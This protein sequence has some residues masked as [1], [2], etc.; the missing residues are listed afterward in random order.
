M[1]IQQRIDPATD[2]HPIDPTGAIPAARGGD[3][4]GLIDKVRSAVFWRSGSQI[5]AQMVMWASTFLVIRL[6]DPGDYG[7]FAMTQVILVFLNLLNGYGLASALVR[8]RECTR[9]QQQQVLGML[10]LLNFSLGFAQFLCAPFVA[11]YFGEPMVADLL[12]VQALLYVATPFM[13]LPHALLSRS[14]DFKRPAQVH[15]ISATLSAT[16]AYLCASNGWGVWTLIAA[17]MVFF[18]AEGIGMTWAARSWMW[19]RFDF[20]GSGHLFRFGGAMMLVQFFWFVQSQSDVFIAGR[21]LSAHDLG[22]YTTALFLTQILAGK[23]VPPLNEV[24]FAAYAKIQDDRAMVATGFA[25]TVRLILLITLPAYFGMAVTADP[26]IRTFLGEKW[27]ETIPVIPILALAMPFLTLQILFAP[28]TNAI[29]RPGIA[30]SNAI[31]GGIILPLAFLIGV[32]GGVIGLATGWLA[33]MILL[34]LVSAARALPVIGTPGLALARAIAP[35]LLASAAMAAL[36]LAVDAMLPILPPAARLGVLAAT[37]AVAYAAL[38][39]FF[40]RSLVREAW[41]LLRKRPA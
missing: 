24:A 7:L 21:V 12:R 1:T 8:E 40:A 30:L 39:W 25:R 27:V 33:G 35:G 15:L 5:L 18:Y 19:P 17:P 14:M 26:M 3:A 32:Q 37:G 10:I 16:T 4:S 41:S 36:V 11:S 23:F 28:A 22:V 9:H 6:L 29:G 2:A 13:A 20:R 34:T 38:L 31:A